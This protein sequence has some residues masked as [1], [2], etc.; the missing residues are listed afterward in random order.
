[1]SNP[2]VPAGQVISQSP[3]AGTSVKEQRTVHLVVSKGV[4][5]IT[6]PDLTDMTVDQAKQRLK[7]LGLVIGKIS[8]D[9]NSDKPDGVILMQSPPGD[10]K[11]SK[12]AVIDITVNK[13]KSKQTQVPSLVGMTIKDAKAALSAVG[14]SLGSVSGAGDQTAL[15]TSQSPA[16]GSSVDQGSS[17]NVVSEAKSNSNSS[18]SSS[19][20]N[21]SSGGNTT[22]GTVDITVPSGKQNQSV[23]ITVSDD[24]GSHTVYDGTNHPGDRIVKDVSGTGR[25]RV[26][27]YLN[28]ALVQ[29]QAL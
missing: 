25:V 3:E 14:L 24:S 5:D 7:D 4:G 20:D 11:V 16:A 1:M 10:S 6:V 9:S 22:K 27:V 2:D 18:S 19:S 17:V 15:V 26:Q 12:G 28:G 8:T 21:S 29:D 23:R 13:I